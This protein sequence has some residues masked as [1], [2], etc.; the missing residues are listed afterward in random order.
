MKVNAGLAL[1]T[2]QNMDIRDIIIKRLRC[3]SWQQYIPNRQ[4]PHPN[5]AL[6]I[7]TYNYSIV[8]EG[9][10]MYRC[11][12]THLPFSDFAGVPRVRR[13]GFAELITSCLLSL[14]IRTWW[15]GGW[16]GGLRH[17]RV[18]TVPKCLRMVMKCDQQKYQWWCWKKHVFS[19][20]GANSGLFVRRLFIL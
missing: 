18:G 4:K 19:I 14:G 6:N 20:G 5:E 17:T 16:R 15:T 13:R 9:A 3:L 10:R 2:I 8:F 1:A 7:Y 11:L 12:S